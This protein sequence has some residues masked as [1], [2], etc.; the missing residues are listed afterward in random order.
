MVVCYLHLRAVIGEHVSCG[1][2]LVISDVR[3]TSFATVADQFIMADTSFHMSSL[4]DD[5][6]VV[7]VAVRRIEG[8]LNFV[9]TRCGQC[10]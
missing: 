4:S 7:A 9:E 2:L 5:Q 10:V 1:K 3:A 6:T 8:N